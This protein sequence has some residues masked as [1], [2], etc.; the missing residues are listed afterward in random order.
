MGGAF[1]T[2]TMAQPHH[3]IACVRCHVN[4]DPASRVSYASYEILGMMLR[5]VPDN[6]RAAAQVDDSTCLSCHASVN[7]GVIQAKGVRIKHAQCAKNNRCTD[8]HS[9]TA[10]GDSVKWQRLSHMDTCL[11]CHAA[12]KVRESCDTCH[13]SMSSSNL[14]TYGSW[15][16][17]HGPSWKT[18]HGMGDWNTCAACHA[19]GYCV[20]CHN[21]ELPHNADFMRT[22]GVTALTQRTDCLVCHRPT[23]CSNCHGIDM[24]HPVSFAPVHPGV[25]QAKGQ[26]T[27]LKC[28][29]ITD[30]ETCHIKHVHPGGAIKPP[31]VSQ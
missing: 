11:D 8:C 26:S 22:H 13:A 4:D 25:V 5:V 15:Y 9:D 27:C 29:V 31:K 30:C 1:K 14:M 28:H 3:N 16:V 20:R 17:T 12:N 21:L 7:K 19:P 2:D 23:F 18:A 10:H 6:G 24:P